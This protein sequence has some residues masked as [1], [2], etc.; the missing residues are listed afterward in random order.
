MRRLFAVPVLILIL[1]SVLSDPAALRA[2]E[3]EDGG[4]QPLASHAPIKTDDPLWVSAQ[5]TLTRGRQIFRH[6]RLGS[7]TFFSRS[8]KLHRGLREIG[9]ATAL[10]VGVKV[11]SEALPA[12][13]L[14]AIQDGTIDLEDP[15]NTVALILAGAVVGVRG[16]QASNGKLFEV[17]VT[18]AFCHSTV[19]DSVAP[20][21]GKRLDGWA[22]RDLNVGAILS[23]AGNLRPLADHL[24][25][26]VETV[27]AVLASWGPGKFDAHLNLDGKAFRP[28]GASA[29]VL[30]PPAFGLAGVNLA[31]YTGWGSVSFW[32]ALVANLE[33]G[34]KG[35]FFDP[36]LQDAEKFPLAAA[37]GLGDVSDDP[38]VITSKLAAL[39]VYQ[40]SLPAPAPPAGSF[41][42]EAAARGE[43]LF[44]GRAACADCHVPPLYTEP[45]WNLHPAEDI[46]ID[47]FQSNRSP[48]G[49]YR[50]T[51]L[52]GLWTHTQGGF[53]HDG[54]FPTLLDVVDHYDSFQG[55]GLSQTEKADLVEF[56]LSL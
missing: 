54:R 32:N 25:V 2:A 21:I 23:L 49:A 15:A 27:R 35:R 44:L 3:P 12:A 51:P 43:A 10:A 48:T 52:K 36:R 4:L 33:M 5:D 46:G 1:G 18:C 39:H 26:D 42:I 13:V 41:D 9:P 24:G 38:D 37:A 45:G 47:D 28:D 7:H 22:N 56:L 31:T 16:K 55:L 14:Q 34:G 20:G 11:D 17:G 50:T 29:A 6:D 40:L 19:D 30:I 8:L 53:Y